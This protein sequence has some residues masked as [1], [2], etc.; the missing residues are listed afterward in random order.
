V[1][2]KLSDLTLRHVDPSKLLFAQ[3]HPVFHLTVPDW[4]EQ[5][6]PGGVTLYPWLRGTVLANMETKAEKGAYFVAVGVLGLY[7]SD[8]L[9]EAQQEQFNGE[10]DKSTLAE[11]TDKEKQTFSLRVVDDLFPFVRNELYAL[12]GRL[13]GV[14]GV[15]LQ[16]HPLIQDGELRSSD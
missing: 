4:Y 14:N 5:T 11:A 3:R 7:V 6:T 9:E 8:Q 1:V 2:T 10:V 13:Q 15:M 16:P 12:S